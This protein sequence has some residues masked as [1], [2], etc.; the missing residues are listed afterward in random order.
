MSAARQPLDKV[1]VIGSGQVGILS[2]IAM[3]RA[4]PR[5]EVTI[6]GMP[7]E[8]NAFA[9]TAQTA[10][11]FTCALHDRLG[12]SEAQMIARTGASHRLIMRYFGWAG[13]GSHGAMSYGAPSDPAMQSSFAREW[14]GGSKTASSGAGTKARPVAEA[15]ADAGRF[16]KPPED[17]ESPLSEVAYALRWNVPAYRQMLITIAQKL[18]IG[19]VSGALGEVKHD[20]DGTV[21]TINVAGHGTIQGDLF[22]DCGGPKAPLLSQ[23]PGYDIEDWGSYLPGKRMHYGQPGQAM[24]ALEDRTSLLPIGWLS[25]LAG[26]DGLQTAVCTREKISTDEVVGALGGPVALSVDIAPSR[27][28]QP[29]IGNVIALGDAAAR[30]EPLAGLPLHLAHRTLALFLEM[31]PGK[32]IELLERAEFNRRA[33]FMMNGVRDMI[34]MHYCAPQALG[35]FGVQT[36]P[37]IERTIDQFTRR[38]RLPFQEET[39]FLS[40][41][42]MSLLS[43][44]GL[45]PGTPPQ[46]SEMSPSQINALQRSA[47][48][49]ADEAVEFAPP[50]QQWMTQL[51]SQSSQ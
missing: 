32:T 18:G 5:C 43:A 9:D 25:E 28:L 41:E 34:A 37:H 31:L 17:R 14:G 11:P 49:K 44:L 27:C 47:S 19:H 21:H 51:L 6:V 50:Y 12:I 40:F 36:P 26:R 1:V 48:Q 46:Y 45:T 15:L 7:V 24:L 38:G 23:L 42:T 13:T 22:I 35:A 8:A 10:L 39:P 3:K 30:F 29:W 4:L 2:A 33:S 20:E 16:A